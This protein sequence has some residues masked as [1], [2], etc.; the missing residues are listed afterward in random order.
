M[1]KRRRDSDPL[2]EDIVEEPQ[3]S[4]IEDSDIPAFGDEDF[5]EGDFEETLASRASM[6]WT[7]PDD[8]ASAGEPPYVDAEFEEI[9]GEAPQSRTARL[10][11]WL[12]KQKRKRF[13]RGY[14]DTGAQLELQ[15]QTQALEEAK[16]RIDAAREAQI[17]RRLGRLN[18]AGDILTKVATLG[19]PIKKKNLAMYDTPALRTLTRPSA[20]GG[21]TAANVRGGAGGGLS[22]LQPLKA[23]AAPPET[24][25]RSLTFPNKKLAA[26][27]SPTQLTA[28]RSAVEVPKAVRRN[29][30]VATDAKSLQAARAVNSPSETIRRRPPD[31]TALKSITLPK[32]GSLKTETSPKNPRAIPLARKALPSPHL[33]RADE[34]LVISRAG[35]RAA[36]S[37][38]STSRIS[39]LS[40]APSLGS[41]SIVGSGRIPAA[42]VGGYDT[43]SPLARA[44]MTPV[45]FSKPTRLSMANPQQ[46]RL[47]GPSNSSADT[48]SSGKGADTS[49]YRRKM[50]QFR[51]QI[52][53]T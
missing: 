53:R 43:S 1:V 42:G 17:N 27:N 39:G 50:S 11:G 7:T 35:L 33:T 10:R 32:L 4:D 9:P 30:L 8:S 3:I 5:Q 20:P 21:G 52:G 24:D 18:K 28:V 44:S 48:V 34:G 41:P 16:N 45:R 19:G 12:A 40:R 2:V 31:L 38:I 6:D 36:E 37:K 14:V 13:I 23:A 29:N 26:V 46:L 49:Y 25:L 22:R 15:R 47:S 51:K